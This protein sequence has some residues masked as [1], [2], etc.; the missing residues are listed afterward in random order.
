MERA[1]SHVHDSRG[2]RLNGDAG[3]S[4]QRRSAQR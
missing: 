2:R 4:A 1:E 3:A